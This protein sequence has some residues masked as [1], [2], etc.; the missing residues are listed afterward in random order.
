MKNQATTNKFF[1]ISNS[2]EMWGLKMDLAGKYTYQAFLRSLLEFV[3][4]MTGFQILI[5]TQ[6]KVFYMCN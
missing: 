4:N 6:H 5:R 3:Y 2:P 1:S